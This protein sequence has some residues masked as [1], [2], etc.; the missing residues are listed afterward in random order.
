MREFFTSPF[1]VH[2]ENDRECQLFLIGAERA[3]EVTQA[4]GQHRNGAVYQVN[5][6][7]TF[8]C[9]FV[10]CTSFFYIVCNIGNMYSDFPQSRFDKPDGQ[11]IVKVF[12]IF[13]VDGKGRYGPEIFPFGI[14]GFRYLGRNLFGGGLYVFGYT[15]GSPYS[16]RMACIS[17]VFSPALPKMSITCPIGFLASFGHSIIFTT[18]L[19]PFFPPSIYLWE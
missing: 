2:I 4:F 18:A 14:V 11:S 19:S 15:Y 10:Y 12:C 13:G 16:A 7:C 1:F 3:D 9:F 8:F 17:V 6:S 5:G